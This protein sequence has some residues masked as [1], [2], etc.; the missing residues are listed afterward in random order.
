MATSFT[1]TPE[2]HVFACPHCHE[3]INT[4]MTT[5]TFCGAPIDPAAAEQAAAETAR[6]SAACSDASYLKVMAG[7]LIPFIGLMFVPLLTLLGLVGFEFLRFAIPFMC[8]RWWIKNRNIKT[9]DPDFSNARG[10]AIWV[11]IVAAIVLIYPFFR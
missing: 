9:S 11:S 1:L 8:I 2:V 3:T 4:S 10:T 7:L 5:C 6:V